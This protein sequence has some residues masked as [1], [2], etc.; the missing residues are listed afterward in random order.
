MTGT[1]HETKKLRS[2]VDE[3]EELREKEQKKG[4]AEMTEDANDGEDHAGEIAVRVA[5]EDLGRIPVMR[6]ESGRDPDK[7][8]EEVE[9]EHVRVGG[10]MR[11]GSKGRKEEGV[12]DDEKD[13][14]DDGLRDFD[15]VDAG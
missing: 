10:R 6:P 9:R 7:G 2:G 5:Y 1:G 13:G 4:L 15:A 3:V 12:V 14:D 8:E 11:V